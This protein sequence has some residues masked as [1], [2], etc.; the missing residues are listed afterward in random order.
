MRRVVV[1]GLGIV[2]SIGNNAA[3]VLESLKAGRSGITA[4]EDMKE[5]GFRS[6]IAG[7]IKGLN[8]VDMIDNVRFVLWAQVR[9]MPIWRWN[10]RLQMQVWISHWCQTNAQDWWQDQAAHQ[11]VRCSRPIRLC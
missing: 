11:P 10:R 5:Y 6:Q 1:T 7:D 2:S 4:N 9:P 8:L 3:E